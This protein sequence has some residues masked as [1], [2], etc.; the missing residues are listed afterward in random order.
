MT[1]VHYFRAQG[2]FLFKLNYYEG[3]GYLL[4]G[5]RDGHET[6]LFETPRFAPGGGSF[7]VVN[8]A[9]ESG[10]V[11]DAV[12]IWAVQSS[13]PARVFAHT[14]PDRHAGYAFL[15][16]EGMDRLLLRDLSRSEGDTSARIAV[17]R[18]SQGWLLSP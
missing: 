11:P 13:G 16:W 6:V 14:P 12:E 7:A 2:F 15:A 1:P 8:G 4:V 10:Y 9:S 17:D 18:T 3:G 5:D